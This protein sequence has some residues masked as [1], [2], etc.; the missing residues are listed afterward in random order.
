MEKVLVVDFDKTLVK[1]D[2][3]KWSLY[4]IALNRIYLF[5][6]LFYKSKGWVDFKKRVLQV[7]NNK[8]NFYQIVNNDV[9]NL[10]NQI[11]GR[12]DKVV[13][14]SASPESFLIEYI[15]QGMFDGVFGSIEIN[16][17]GYKKLV[18]IQEHFGNNFAYIGDSKDDRVIFNEAKM[19]IKVYKNKIEIIKNDFI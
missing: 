3:F 6:Y 5:P 10:I 9:M 8:P 18:F 2:V 16:L 13:L 12:F 11:K 19:A 4:Q 17:K 14:V 7:T 15:P 1:L